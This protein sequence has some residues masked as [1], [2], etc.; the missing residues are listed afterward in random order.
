MFVTPKSL[1]SVDC[2]AAMVERREEKKE[3]NNFSKKS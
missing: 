1:S 2:A 3:T